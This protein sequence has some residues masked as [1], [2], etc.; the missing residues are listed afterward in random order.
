LLSHSSYGLVF[1]EMTDG[2]TVMHYS[3][4]RPTA[5]VVY[6]TMLTYASTN[7]Q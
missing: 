6:V 4:H 5:P 3:I 7:V 2:R 1:D